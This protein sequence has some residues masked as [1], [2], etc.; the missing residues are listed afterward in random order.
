MCISNGLST[1][2]L[3]SVLAERL[4]AVGGRAH[5]EY[6]QARLTFGLF[7]PR[8]FRERLGNKLRRTEELIIGFCS[9]NYDYE[10]AIRFRIGIIETTMPSSYVPAI[11]VAVLR[12]EVENLEVAEAQR[13]AYSQGYYYLRLPGEPF[14]LV[15]VDHTFHNFITKVV[16]GQD[17]TDAAML[18]VNIENLKLA[19]SEIDDE[20]VSK[21]LER[22]SDKHSHACSLYVAT[23]PKL[24][25]KLHEKGHAR[26]GLFLESFGLAWR[27][28]KQPG[29]AFETR[30]SYISR[31][32][33]VIYS[34]FGSDAL[35]KVEVLRSQH[36][37]GVPTN[38]LLDLLAAMDVFE[39]IYFALSPSQRERLNASSLTARNL[40][41]SFSALSSNACSGEK[42]TM[43]QIKGT[44]RR[45][46]ALAVHFRLG[47]GEEC[48]THQQSSR[49][50][51]LDDEV[52]PSWSDG[53]ADDA[54][55]FKDIRGRA[56]QY[57]SNRMQTRD[58]NKWQGGQL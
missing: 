44:V 24:V 49:K 40:E 7:F 12:R 35:C 36:T 22:G 41:S 25:A 47:S 39:Q 17:G 20:I 16:W 29:L 26:E 50:R 9:F 51:K 48:Y 3:K 55:F 14:Q 5:R 27:A 31:L 33:L 52:S 18:V 8:S 6:R 56:E 13:E 15:D 2:G 38:Q 11:S 58:H 42:M 28:W 43:E 57:C 10:L 37:A 46:D 32:R 54:A 4:A 45:S 34:V 1:V 30:L 53:T 21:I 19:S 23:H